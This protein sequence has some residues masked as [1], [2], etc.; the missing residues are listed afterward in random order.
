LIHITYLDHLY[1]GFQIWSW[2]PVNFNDPLEG[3][4]TISMYWTSMASSAEIHCSLVLPPSHLKHAI[5]NIY[6]MCNY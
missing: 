4:E 6:K 5:A 1:K 3:I 2:L